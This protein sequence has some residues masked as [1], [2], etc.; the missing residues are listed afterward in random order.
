M[1]SVIR[2]IISKAV[3]VG[4]MKNV[5]LSV[6]VSSAL[7]LL[8]LTA[9]KLTLTYSGTN[10]PAGYTGA[11][12][13]VSCTSCHSGTAITSG[14]L[15][16]SVKFTLGRPKLEYIPDSTYTVTIS[17]SDN[18]QNKYGFQTVALLNSNNRNAGSITITNSTRTTRVTKSVSGSVR[19]YVTHTSAGVIGSNGKISWT[20]EWKAPSANVGNIK[21][22][23]TVNSSNRNGQRSGDKIIERAFEIKPSSDLPTAS[24]SASPQN[25]CLGDT[26]EFTASG[27]K[28]PTKYAWVFPNATPSKSSSQKVKVVFNTAGAKT[29][30]LTV[31]NAIG[32]SPEKKLTYTVKATPSNQV[33]SSG[34][35]SFCDGDS[36]TLRAP[37]GSSWQWSTGETSQDIVVKNSQN[38]DVVVGASNGC[39]STSKSL[40]VTKFPLVKPSLQNLNADTICED[41]S[42]RLVVDGALTSVDVY[43]GSN[44][45]SA[46]SDSRVAFMSAP[47]AYSFQVQGIDANGCSSDFSSA[48]SAVVD[49]RLKAPTILCDSATADYL[50]IGWDEI[51]GAT[52]YELSTDGGDSWFSPS[53]TDGSRKHRVDGLTFSTEVDF[54]IRATDPGPCQLSEVGMATCKT[55]QCFKVR[56]QLEVNDTLCKGDSLK[57]GI[58][59]LNLNNYSLAFDN[60]AYADELSYA[61]VPTQSRELKISF[62]DSFSLSCKPED[63][64]ID[65][66]VSE[67]PVPAILHTWPTKVN[68]ENRV[69]KVNGAIT[70]D[71]TKLDVYGPYLGWDWVGNG[72][73]D[74]GN[75]NY[76]FLAGSVSGAQQ[77][78]SYEVENAF[79]C[80]GSTKDTVLV[81]E[82]TESDFTINYPG[83][84]GNVNFE[85]I[86]KNATSRIWDFGDGNTDTS[87]APTHGYDQKGK[88]TVKLTSSKLNS[89]C[90]PAVT[91]KEVEI[92]V[93]SVG[94]SKLGF[95]LFPNPA[96]D[97]LELRLTT[98]QT[99]I[100]V[101]DIM[102]KVVLEK[103]NAQPNTTLDVG[104]LKPGT[105]LLRVS[106]ESSYGQEVFMKR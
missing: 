36:V 61:V 30:K 41:D 11:P 103:Q 8:C 9:S 93:G 71:G 84:D 7:F 65:V 10:P 97:K 47:G 95:D 57:I 68:G 19:Q 105:Y 44:K 77:V 82:I 78:I 99:Q 43:E 80:K 15:Y 101:L 6:W 90:P 32:K 63:T 24:I 73:V 16:D 58:S 85:A 54:Q 28:N 38:V 75:G 91:S 18:N 33:D 23:V 14:A 49:A 45:I 34:A 5:R 35:L 67:L 76:E 104:A 27:T 56:Y 31:T 92:I 1:Q 94:E 21:F 86:E 39:T 88:Y 60:G 3:I 26:V 50:I 17:Y 42:I 46:H 83:I 48:I 25:I 13:D 52:G 69:C 62:V 72:I 37:G 79:G 59:N 55:K 40:T 96:T 20:F 89:A 2:F 53:F 66:F 106:S 29:V 64:L 81:D 100:Q 12:N 51:S 70:L 102:G 87:K 4:S 74:R 98:A 22:Y